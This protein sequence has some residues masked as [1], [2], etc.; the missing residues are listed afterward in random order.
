L[1]RLGVFL[2]PGPTF[3]AVARFVADHQRIAPSALAPGTQLERDLGIT[4]DDGVALL[5]AFFREFSV[6]YPE[7]GPDA[8]YLF[9]SEG[10]DLLAPLRRLFGHSAKVVLPITL[11]YLHLAASRHRWEDPPECEP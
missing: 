5:A 3:D 10:S 6:E 11:G 4:G 7:R 9:H 8:P 2:V 1:D